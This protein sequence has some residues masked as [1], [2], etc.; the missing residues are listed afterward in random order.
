MSFNNELIPEVTCKYLKANV[1]KH[2]Y[3]YNLM[4]YWGL[5]FRTIS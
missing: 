3:V 5:S 1:L 2:I 4:C